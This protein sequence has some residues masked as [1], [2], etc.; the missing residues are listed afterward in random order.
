MPAALFNI[1]LQLGEEM[2]G[3]KQKIRA[4]EHHDLLKLGGA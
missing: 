3:M 1:W 2:R 4:P